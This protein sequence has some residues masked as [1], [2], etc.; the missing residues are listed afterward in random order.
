[1][2]VFFRSARRSRS[3]AR[4]TVQSVMAVTLSI[5]LS[6]P[7]PLPL[8]AQT[9]A[10]AQAWAQTAPSVFDNLPRLGDAGTEGFSEQAERRLAD[11]II[12]QVRRD[13]T[14]LDDAEAADYLNGLAARL[15]ESPAMQGERVRLFAVRQSS[16]NAFALP[17]GWIGVHAGLIA[18]AGS[19]SELAA[20]IAHE[21]GHV[22]QRHIGRMLAQQRQASTLAMAAMVLAAIAARSS[23]DA[24]IGSL[25][26]GDHLARQN[27]LAFSR[28]AEREADRVG[29]D[30]LRQA[31]YDPQAM[32]GFFNRLQAGRLEH[33]AHAYLRTHPLTG[34]RIND[35]RLRTSPS[36]GATGLGPETEFTLMKARMRVLGVRDSQALY[37]LRM[38]LAR[39]VQESGADRFETWFAL[40]VA[41]LEDREY[42][43]ARSALDG[44]RKR[45]GAHHPYFDRLAVAID[46]AAGDPRAALATSEVAVARFPEARALVR[47]QAQVL[48]LNRE[49]ARALE[50]L[51]PQ[52]E[53]WPDDG[54]LWRW[55]SEAHALQ[56]QRALAHWAAAEE[57]VLAGAWQGAAD[58]L[59]RAQRAGDADFYEGS[60]IDARLRMV[61]E[62]LR[63]ETEE[64]QRQP[65]R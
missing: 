2:K 62:E 53:R 48:V 56:N 33:T 11:W 54:W 9:Q 39:D 31:G 40:A 15:V 29:L 36:E 61:L 14:Y 32:V 64:L 23:P 10:W 18:A 17:G 21:I 28:E 42:A 20:V 24:A 55:R 46:V 52:L 50:F 34:E 44:A 63:R 4:L 43:Q 1:M 59:R 47:L 45:L 12:R 26:L 27:V 8:P 7:L 37:E 51:K 6:V 3:I 35:I 49:G 25:M 19:E 22:L 16:V 30:L 57:F 65:G 13:P 38:S 41:A 60:R 58:Q 5:S